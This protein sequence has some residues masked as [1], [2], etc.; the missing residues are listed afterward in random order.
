MITRIQ[1]RN[2]KCLKD[3]DVR[4]SPFQVLVGPN[5]SGKSTFMDVLGFIRDMLWE[6]EGLN[7]AVEKR[8]RSFDALTWNGEGGEIEFAVE[9]EL[10]GA[11]RTDRGDP[12]RYEIAFAVREHVGGLGIVRERVDVIP[13]VAPAGGGPPTQVAEAADGE[14]LGR[15][16]LAGNSKSVGAEVWRRSDAG[17]IAVEYGP[18]NFARSIR[19]VPSSRSALWDASYRVAEDPAAIAGR[20]GS[21]WLYAV[22]SEHAGAVALDP[23]AMA[24]PCRP[25]VP[26]TLVGD[27]SNIAKVVQTLKEHDPK[28]YRE[29]IAH[30]GTV[31]EDI[32]DIVVVEQEHDRHLYIRMLREGSPPVSAWAMSDGELRFLGLTLLA[33]M[34][35][36]EGVFLVEEPENGMHPQAIQS[37]FDS[38]RSV[39]EGQVFVAT[40]SPLVV[41]CADLDQLLC[42]SRSETDG[43]RVIRG[44]E[45]RA[46]RNWKKSVGLG[47]LYA[48]GVF[49]DPA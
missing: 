22:L 20:E 18:K 37:V 43:T 5:G 21:A 40:H 36:N 10:P 4:L 48:S 31:L 13:A 46:M 24:V 6:R 7:A 2:Y 47:S 9:L 32:R 3:V 35:D 16:G 19:P 41:G 29:W 38:L 39:Y 27:G 15:P 30:L 11:R 34:P 14:I 17:W 12:W 25:D 49:D 33:Y 26:K 42:F 28:S 1:A 23:A 45:H 8:A 44:Q